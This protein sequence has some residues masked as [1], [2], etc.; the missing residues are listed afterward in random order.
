MS[1]PRSDAVTRE[2]LAALAGRGATLVDI[3]LPHL[4]LGIPIYYLVATAEASS[5]L[6]RYDG[7]RYGQRAPSADETE[8]IRSMYERTRSAG[9]GAEVKRRILLGTFVLSAGYRDA[10]YVQAQRA[11]TLIRRDYESAFRR[12]DVIA[13]PTS[14]TP[15]FL[16]G[17]GSTIH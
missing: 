17:N 16:L 7:V 12:V 11:R 1:T 3:E 14:P 15:A 8:S 10:Y 13:T 6:A 4:D 2:A 9:F 5:N